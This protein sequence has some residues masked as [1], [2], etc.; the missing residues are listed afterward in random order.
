MCYARALFAGLLVGACAFVLA[1]QTTA[2]TIIV[3]P[4]DNFGRTFVDVVGDLAVGDDKTFVDK[5]G[6]FMDK[7]GT[8]V[9]PEKV[10]VTLMSNGGQFLP[11]IGIGRVHPL[12]RHCNVRA[13]RSDVCKCLCVCLARRCSAHG[14]C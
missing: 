4:P 2:A 11:A 7:L 13:S 5:V 14:R 10:I 1:Q 3:N 6:T 12:D 9:E 8:P